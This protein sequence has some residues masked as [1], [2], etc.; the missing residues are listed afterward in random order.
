[1][2]DWAVGAVQLLRWCA[3]RHPFN[4][5]ERQRLAVPVHLEKLRARRI[6]SLAYLAL[7]L[8][9]SVQRVYQKLW[10][11]QKSV[12]D[13]VIAALKQRSVPTLVFKGAEFLSRHF[14]SRAIG[15]LFDVDLL[16]KRATIEEAK[17]ALHSIGLRQA[18]WN[19]DLGRL[20]DRDVA[21]TARLE[22]AHYELAPFSV[23]QELPL[24]A[25]E[26][27]IV[28]EWNQHPLYMVDGRAYAVVEVDLHHQVAS[29]IETAPFFQRAVPSA[30]KNALTLSPADLMW[31]T[32]SRFYTEVALH[33]KRSLRDFAYLAALLGSTPIDWD[34]L[35]RATREDGLSSSVYYYF[36]FLNHLTNSLIPTEVI[37]ELDPARS[38]RLRDWGWQLG[39]LFEFI[40]NFP[41]SLTTA[42]QLH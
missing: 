23:C 25:D 7:G 40:E 37:A 42:N 31:F 10:D 34:V 22:S 11:L 5:A 6:D 39:Q 35:L 8:N 24:D 18:I 16:I 20:T 3:K 28:R 13:S 30:L 26:L 14:H 12:L 36:V 41:S 19:R 1:V 27:A 21:E 32:T 4:D 38:P 9:P 15:M 17:I 2:N 33:G 29:D